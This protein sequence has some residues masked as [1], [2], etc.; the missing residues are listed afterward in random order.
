MTDVNLTHLVGSLDV[1]GLE[2][3]A[4]RVEARLSFYDGVDVAARVAS[5]YKGKVHWLARRGACRAFCGNLMGKTIV[6]TPS[7]PLVTC[8]TCL[9]AQTPLDIARLSARCG[10]C[11]D[12]GL[13]NATH[14][15]AHT[16]PE[17]QA[18][19]QTNPNYHARWDTK[20]PCPRCAV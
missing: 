18:F 12:S 5:G 7:R 9:S 20:F 4:A 17:A 13:I 3:L 19:L 15:L 11:E 14:A 8:N 16:V 1:E 6:G 2:D 10:A